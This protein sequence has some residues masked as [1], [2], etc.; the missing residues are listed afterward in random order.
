MK[1]L[2]GNEVTEQEAQ[3]QSPMGRRGRRKPVVKAGFAAL[4]GTGP[5]GETCGSCNHIVRLRYSRVY[6]KCRLMER[7]WTC[8]PGT[9]IL[10]RSPACRRWEEQTEDED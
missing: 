4:P 8:G 5:E 7:L 3:A 2:F 9:D 6:P 10:V 1:D